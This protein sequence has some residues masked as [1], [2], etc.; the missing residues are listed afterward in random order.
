MDPSDHGLKP[1][2]L[3]AKINLSSSSVDYLRYF[4]AV[5]E[6]LLTHSN[7]MVQ[8]GSL[9][10]WVAGANGKEQSKVHLRVFS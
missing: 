3:G 9:V 7:L 8:D 1:L 2:K 4:T 5:M 10:F 6:S